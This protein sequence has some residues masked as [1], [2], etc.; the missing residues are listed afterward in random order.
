MINAATVHTDAVFDF[1]YID[2]LWQLAQTRNYLFL[3]QLHN[4]L[5]G[6][7][8]LVHDSVQTATNHGLILQKPFPC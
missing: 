7:I 6:F 8:L 4:A 3:P 5:T 2:A 1:P